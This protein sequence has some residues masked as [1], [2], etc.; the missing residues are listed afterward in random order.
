[1][2]LIIITSPQFV[3]DEAQ[4][5]TALFIAGLQRLHLRKPHASS[6]ALEELIQK[7]PVEFHTRI[8]IHDAFELTK[9]Y[10]L[11]GVHLNSRHPIAPPDYQGMRSCS[12]HTLAEVQDKHTA[13]DYLFLSPIYDSIS[14]EG[15]SSGFARSTLDKASEAQIIN[16]KV[17][18]LGGVRLEHLA[19]LK[20]WG[21]GG[22]AFLGDIW[23]GYQDA[24]DIEQVVHHFL[25][26][27]EE[28]DR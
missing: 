13:S 24:Q 18:A 4:V 23:G 2:K 20:Q 15:Y 19:E 1:M 5:L 12:C 21:F 28:A 22:A 17:I 9:K 7:I 16:E 26:L 6:A 25:D 8:S 14:K 10:A 11:G 3:T 27:Q